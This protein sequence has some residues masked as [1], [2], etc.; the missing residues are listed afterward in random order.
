MTWSS[1]VWSDLY[2]AASHTDTSPRDSKSSVQSPE[3]A[4]LSVSAENTTFMLYRRRGRVLFFGEGGRRDR[5]TTSLNSKHRDILSNKTWAEYSYKA[6]MN[7][8]GGCCYIA[9]FRDVV[10]KLTIHCRTVYPEERNITLKN[11]V[12]C[13]PFKAWHLKI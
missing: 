2:S 9:T 8:V 7:V 4:G 10:R 6:K 5:G 3:K 11:K 12:Q 1:W 13:E